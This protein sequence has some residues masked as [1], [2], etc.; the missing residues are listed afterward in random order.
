M[1][2]MLIIFYIISNQFVRNDRQ[3]LY[4]LCKIFYNYIIMETPVN[5]PQSSPIRYSNLEHGRPCKK[6][7]TD[8][9]ESSI[10]K[11][12]LPTSSV[13]IHREGDN[14]LNAVFK[15]M[16]NK[17]IYKIA[18]STQI[19][20]E[21]AAYD[22]LPKTIQTGFYGIMGK[23]YDIKF[24]TVKEIKDLGNGQK[25]L[26]LELIDGLNQNTLLMNNSI[27]SSDEKEK[28]LKETLKFLETYKIKYDKFGDE[29][30]DTEARGNIYLLKINEKDTKDT[31]VVIDFELSQVTGGKKRST[32]KKRKWSLKYKRK[33]NC[34]KPKGVSQKQYCSKKNKTRR[35]K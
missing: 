27:L 2:I 35:N 24:P 20:N 8:Q 7:K 25:L 9:I 29:D 18:K 3:I 15:D 26:V 30:G 12:C 16:V 13:R 6:R 11:A 31:I 17:S 4:I 33:I 19:N 10:E 22:K 28:L 14:P 1:I 32:I 21:I 23:S 34:K 5:T